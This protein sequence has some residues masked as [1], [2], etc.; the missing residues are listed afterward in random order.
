M[1]LFVVC[2]KS[3]V[4]EM[5]MKH[6]LERYMI[7]SQTNRNSPKTETFI[8]QITTQSFCNVFNDLFFQRV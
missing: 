7:Y 5:L 3:E 8:Q 6:F 2:L 4:L 1:L